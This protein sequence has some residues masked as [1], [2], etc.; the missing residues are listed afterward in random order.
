MYKVKIRKRAKKFKKSLDLKTQRRIDLLIEEL[1]A[2][3]YSLPYR[4]ISDYKDTYRVQIG[5]DMR[6]S[7]SINKDE[8]IIEIIK[9]GFRESFYSKG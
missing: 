2:N 5:R 7:Y 3:P 6:L 4:K 9:I 1:K 8:L